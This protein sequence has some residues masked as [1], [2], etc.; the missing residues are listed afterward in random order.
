MSP[1]KKDHVYEYGIVTEMGEFKGFVLLSLS[2]AEAGMKRA[3]EMILKLAQADH[4]NNISSM[5]TVME[6][7]YLGQAEVDEA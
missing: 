1:K 4:A 6:I 2:P 3:S 5:V 7:R